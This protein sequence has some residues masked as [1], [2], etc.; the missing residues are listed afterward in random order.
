MDNQKTDYDFPVLNVVNISFSAKSLRI[1]IYSPSEK[2][3][4]ITSVERGASH[5]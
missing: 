2:K 5:P 1:I 3:Q 4:K